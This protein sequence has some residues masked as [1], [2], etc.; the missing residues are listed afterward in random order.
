MLR[1]KKRANALKGFVISNPTYKR[2]DSNLQLLR[3]SFTNLE[4]KF[5]FG[6]QA[7]DYYINGGWIK[8]SDETF[9]RAEGSSKKL[10]LTN[11]TNIPFGPEKLHFHSSIEWRY[12]SLHFPPLLKEV[13]NKNELYHDERLLPFDFIDLIENEHSDTNNFNFYKVPVNQL[14]KINYLL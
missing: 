3:I 5:D 4:T 13:G 12:F 14:S 10:F 1:S 6:Y 9:I 11:A 7:T 2:M 8:I